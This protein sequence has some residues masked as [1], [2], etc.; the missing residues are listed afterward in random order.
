M[1]T[2]SESCKRKIISP[3]HVK[4]K[5]EDLKQENKTVVTLNGSFDLLHAGH[6]YIIHQAKQLGD[7]LIVALN[8]DSSIKSYKGPKRPII[9]L[10]ERIEMMCA[11]EFVDYVTWFDEPDPRA[12]LALIAPH[13]H[14]NGAE[15]GQ[16]CIEAD[17]VLQ[18]GG[19]IHLIDRIPQLATSDIISRIKAL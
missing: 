12:L 1:I 10:P 8:T 16:E 7:V 19:R 14:A 3:H 11:F 2:W 5:S 9:P 17:V 18:Q 4:K 6:L 15:Y 13:I